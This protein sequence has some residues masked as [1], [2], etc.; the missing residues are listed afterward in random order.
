MLIQRLFVPTSTLHHNSPPANQYMVT[1]TFN[2]QLPEVLTLAI[3]VNLSDRIGLGSIP[4]F[5]TLSTV[6]LDL[7]MLFEL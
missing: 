6:K 3:V 1:N 4:F 5:Q 2:R 7:S